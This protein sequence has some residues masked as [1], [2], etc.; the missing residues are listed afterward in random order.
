MKDL[1]KENFSR[2]LSISRYLS[3]LSVNLCEFSVSLW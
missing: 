3:F 1:E 2:V